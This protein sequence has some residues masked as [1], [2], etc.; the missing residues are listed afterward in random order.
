MHE[1]SASLI[2]G[3]TYN[4]AEPGVS[5]TATRT[6]GDVLNSANSAAFSVLG[7]ADHLTFVGVPAAGGTNNNLSQFKF[8]TTS[9][10]PPI[11]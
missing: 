10:F 2:S 5:L 3:I 1:L 7:A 8:N 11:Y 6:A 9:V 4:I